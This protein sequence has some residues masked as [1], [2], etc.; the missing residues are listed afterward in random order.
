[1]AE[2]KRTDL[3]WEDLR[4]F[5]AL[6]RHGSL[7]AAARTLA[8]N[9]A[10]VAR[11]IKALEAS[12]GE[13]LV[14]RR[15]D[16]YV[17]TPAGTRTLAAASDMEAAAQTLGRA[18]TDDAPRGLVRI[19]ASP[20]LSQG[21]LIARLA[22]IPVEY[23]GL[24]IDLA[25]DLRAVSLER[26]ETD[27][28]IRLGRPQDSYLIAR[29]LATIG[30][31]FY[32]TPAV[33]DEVEAGA[34]PI[35]VGFDEV[36]ADIPEA[37]WLS[38]HF[39]RA[40]VSFRANNQVAQATAAKANAGLALLPHYIGRQENGLR[41]CR[42]EPLPPPRE[43]WILTRRQDRKNSP[44]RTVADKLGEMFASERALFETFIEGGANADFRQL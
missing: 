34:D 16:G 40:R 25:T 19:N 36:N 14:E 24:D 13:R 18:G 6:G 30:Y 17:L 39:P 32:G 29:Q 38:R 7:S 35:F 33:C 42:L 8:I 3:D 2:Q 28:A 22:R 26:H 21:F 5:L 10:T 20:A 41:P 1:M 15:P 37:A 23:P 4:V 43:V 31:G 27:I 9:H 11:R 12:L 44:V